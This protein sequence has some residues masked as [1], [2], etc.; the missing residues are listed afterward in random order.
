MENHMT[1]ATATPSKQKVAEP[2]A[3]STHPT[4]P[5][6]VEAPV[7]DRNRNLPTLPKDAAPLAARGTQAIADRMYS[8]KAKLATLPGGE[9]RRI[10]YMILLEATGP[11]SVKAIAD[12]AAKRGL[13]SKTPVFDSVKYHLNLLRKEGYAE[14][15]NDTRANEQV[16]PAKK[17]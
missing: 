6:T 2:I 14:V 16:E 17:A 7:S 10:V 1:T 11:L 3:V 13:V 12:L 9:Q 15:V 4:T 8:L 5:A